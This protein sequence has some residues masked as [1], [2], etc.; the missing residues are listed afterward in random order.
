M[1]ILL[2]A[3]LVLAAPPASAEWE[4]NCNPG[5]TAVPTG[6]PFQPYFC[7]LDGTNGEM[8]CPPGHVLK[9]TGSAFQPYQC[10][11]EA[12]SCPTGYR[13]ERTGNAYAPWKCMQDG[14]SPMCP[15]GTTATATGS[16]FQPW[17]CVTSASTGGGAQPPQPQKQGAGR[18][19]L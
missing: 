3:L 2:L 15:A 19:K 7:A 4:A 13:L 9:P 10:W 5:Y 11:K 18:Q 17:R 8:R 16:A 6:N 14:Q 1:K 12:P